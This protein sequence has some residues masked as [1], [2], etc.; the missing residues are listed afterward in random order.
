MQG[1]CQHW[2]TPF[3]W[4]P[5]TRIDLQI[6]NPSVAVLF[7]AGRIPAN[8]R[9]MRT[10]LR[11][12]AGMDDSQSV[13]LRDRAGMAVTVLTLQQCWI[14]PP[15]LA[16]TRAV[17]EIARVVG[18]VDRLVRRSS[19]SEGGSETHHRPGQQLIDIASAF[20]RHGREVRGR[21]SLEIQIVRLISSSKRI[22]DSIRTSR[23]VRFTLH[24]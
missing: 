11:V 22:S 12:G 18:R 9:G 19:T 3:F 2:C 24:V 17:A 23:H 8:A 15:R 1:S 4:T 7:C 14:A 21:R 13:E 20:A 6:R 10:V 5:L 16:M